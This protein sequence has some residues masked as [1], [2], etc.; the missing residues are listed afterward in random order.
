M[1]DTREKDNELEKAAKPVSKDTKY[2]CKT[3]CFYAGLLFNVG[4]VY[5]AEAGEK[6]PP[7]FVK[8]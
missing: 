5:V 1:A 7:H 3:K 4:D 6:V 2:V 8:Q